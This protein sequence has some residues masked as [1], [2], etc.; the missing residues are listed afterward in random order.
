MNK[1]GMGM[2]SALIVLV[3]VVL[4]L[5][6]FALITLSSANYDQ[7]LAQTAAHTVKEYYEADTLAETIVAQILESA[8]TPAAVLG[9]EIQSEVYDGSET[10]KFTCPV[11]DTKELQVEIVL[12]G[13][14]CSVRAWRMQDSDSWELIDIGLPV[15]QG[16]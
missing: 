14:A 2:G 3:F 1:G 11:T 6:I 10:V 7:T 12:A 16:E 8:T 15:W 4:C 5:T 9:V 13:D